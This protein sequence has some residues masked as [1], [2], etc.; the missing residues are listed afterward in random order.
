MM[1]ILLHVVCIIVQ[2]TAVYST[3]NAQNV[4]QILRGLFVSLLSA[5][6]SRAGIVLV[7]LQTDELSISLIIR[8]HSCGELFA[9]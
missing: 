1:S 8:S 3:T 2:Q 4:F 9:L 7:V 6:L 5:L